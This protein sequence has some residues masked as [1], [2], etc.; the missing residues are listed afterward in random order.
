MDAQTR[1]TVFVVPI[2]AW[3]CLLAGV[4]FNSW[5]ARLAGAP[6]K[7]GV[8]AFVEGTLLAVVILVDMRVIRGPAVI[9]LAAAIGFAWLGF[10]FVLALADYFTR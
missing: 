5:Y 9:R 2:L 4:A 7:A 6:Y 1:R 3:A 8:T 10:F